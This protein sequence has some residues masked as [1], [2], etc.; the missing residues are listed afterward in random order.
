MP[1]VATKPNHWRVTLNWR[2]RKKNNVGGRWTYFY[3]S[4]SDDPPDAAD[5]QQ[6]SAF[7]GG[8][9]GDLSVVSPYQVRIS[10]SFV[11]VPPP[12]APHEGNTLIA[13]IMV[14]RLSVADGAPPDSYM[15]IPIPAPKSEIFRTLHPTL[16][17]AAHPA[18]S[19][20]ANFVIANMGDRYGYSPDLFV[21]GYRGILKWEHQTK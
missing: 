8:I 19:A 4:F 16:V 7:L 18:V 11:L 10:R 5:V 17:D 15:S 2:W 6:L 14:F 13:A 21:G 20:F 3:G 1:W 9:F 12:P